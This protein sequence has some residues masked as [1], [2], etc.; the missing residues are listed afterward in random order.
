MDNFETYAACP[1][2]PVIRWV[3]SSSPLPRFWLSFGSGGFSVTSMIILKGTRHG[4]GANAIRPIPLGTGS[5][6]GGSHSD[7]GRSNGKLFI[8]P[9]P[10]SFILPALA[11]RNRSVERAI[12]KERGRNG[13]LVACPFRTADRDRRKPRRSANHLYRG[14]CIA[15]LVYSFSYASQPW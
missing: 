7:Q 13:I 15:L 11:K 8:Q 1:R 2:G 9:Y 4:R 12:G 5:K 10:A 6:A 3:R 14:Y